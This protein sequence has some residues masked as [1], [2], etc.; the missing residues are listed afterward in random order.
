[1]LIIFQNIFHHTAKHRLLKIFQILGVWHEWDSGK[2][3]AGNSLRLSTNEIMN[4]VY[5]D[6]TCYWQVVNLLN[7]LYTTFDDIISYYNVYKVETI[8]DAYM[9]VSGLPIRNGMRH[10]AEIASTALHLLDAVQKFKIR[11]LPEDKLKL[12]VGIHSGD[13]KVP[14]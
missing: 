7:D 13:W 4:N 3:G 1:M 12:R 10:A 11:H 8:G 2:A 14:V 5:L 9:L 6:A